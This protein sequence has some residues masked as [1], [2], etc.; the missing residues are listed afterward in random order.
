MKNRIL[1]LLASILVGIAP[2]FVLAQCPVCTVAIGVG[3]GLCRY[4]GIDDLITGLWIGALLLAL[5]VVTNNWFYHRFKGYRGLLSV[6]FMSFGW[7]VIYYAMVFIPLTFM[8]I[9]GNSN[10]TFLNIDK[11]LFGSI[12]GIIV[13]LIGLAIDRFI[14]KYTNGKALF[15]YQK[16][17][18]PV[19]LLIIMSIIFNYTICKI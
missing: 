5:G 6:S 8:G 1:L 13:L 19:S 2:N 9:V 4:L 15:L 10:N 12:S 3:V 16:V 18:I 11:L 7:G 17:I 14:R